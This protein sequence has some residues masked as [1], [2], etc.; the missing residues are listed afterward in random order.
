V[1]AEVGRW[2]GQRRLQDRGAHDDDSERT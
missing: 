1:H 2:E